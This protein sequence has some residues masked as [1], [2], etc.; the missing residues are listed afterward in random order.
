MKQT[1][2]FISSVINN[3]CTPNSIKEKILEVPSS[4]ILNLLLMS[5]I[6]LSLVLGLIWLV[7]FEPT[8]CCPMML[9]DNN[10]NTNMLLYPT[11]VPKI[12]I[13]LRDF[14]S[15]TSSGYD[16]VSSRVVKAVIDKMY[17]PLC[18]IF[19]KSFQSGFSN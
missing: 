10:N 14:L 17:V 2:K 18:T 13:I 3:N 1:W 8:A 7:K 15:N 16:D 19:N 5:P 9:I 12:K 4:K 11:D 6:V